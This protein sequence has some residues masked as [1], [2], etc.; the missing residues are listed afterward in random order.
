MKKTQLLISLPLMLMVFSRQTLRAQTADDA[1]MMNKKQWCSGA[2]YMNSSWESY[3]EGTLKRKNLNLGKVSTQ[4]IMAMTNYGITDNLNVIVTGNYV[5]T[6]ASSGTLSGQKGLQDI[7]F[8]LK[9][10]FL[11]L[12]KGENKISLFAVGSI[13]TPITKYENDFQPMSLG[14]GSTNLSAR[15]TADYQ[16]SWFFATLSYAFVFRNNVKLDRNSYYTTELHLT[17]EVE[18]PNQSLSNLNIGYRNKGLIAQVVLMHTQTL[19]GF[20]IRR[21]DMP[22][23]SNRMNMT[24]VGPHVKYF[25]P[26]VKGLQVLGGADF[27][28]DGKA[29][30]LAKSSNTGQFT[31]YSA[32]VY[33]LL[34][35]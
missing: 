12:L 5:W 11:H 20:D 2:T 29:L 21:N 35:L 9:Y 17:N 16:R 6:K 27:A 7:A 30:G 4:S 14:M 19:G 28:F 34:H 15:L 13:S 1:I 33:Y 3:W 24:S 25:L 31:M 22:F 8:D 32:G 18:M 23:V 10:R 26:F